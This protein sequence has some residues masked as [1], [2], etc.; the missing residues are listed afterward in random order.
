MDEQCHMHAGGVLPNIHSV[1][2]A[3][4]KKKGGDPSMSQDF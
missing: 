4:K 1:L 3:P 2:L